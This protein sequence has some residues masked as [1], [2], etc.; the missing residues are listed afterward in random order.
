MVPGTTYT[1]LP[2][3]QDYYTD[4][5]G[6]SPTLS[7]VVGVT[8]SLASGTEMPGG[9]I[10]ITLSMDEAFT[11]TGTPALLLNDGATATY[12]GGSGTTQLTL[13]QTVTTSDTTVAT[14]TI[15]GVSLPS[16]ATVKN[17]VGNVANLRGAVVSFAGLGVDPP[18][19]RAS[20]GNGSRM[21]ST[22]STQSDPS[23]LGSLLSITQPNLRDFVHGSPSGGTAGNGAGPYSPDYHD[24]GSGTLV[25][26]DPVWVDHG[27]YSSGHLIASH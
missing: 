8:A 4:A 27:P 9:T 3:S 13:I 23:S 26:N 20:T 14:L 12:S 10:A 7:D 16:G 24:A 15:T 18:A 11:V 19:P 17:A 6:V 22:A 25:G 5:N 2:G 21:P 1:S